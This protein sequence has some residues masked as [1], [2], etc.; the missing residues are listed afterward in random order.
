MGLLC[1]CDYLIF[2]N[3]Q[4]LQD[5]EIQNVIDFIKSSSID[6]SLL[7]TN[8]DARKTTFTLSQIDTLRFPI[9]IGLARTFMSPVVIFNEAEKEA[10]QNF[11]SIAFLKDRELHNRIIFALGDLLKNP[12]HLAISKGIILFSAF[13]LDL[14]FFDYHGISF[15]S[16][17][18]SH[19]FECA[20]ASCKTT[21]GMAKTISAIEL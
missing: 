3:D 14:D 21:S 4:K 16:S 15:D 17:A 10:M 8:A 12:A 6:L 9:L 7:K 2:F 11:M 1:F 20:L 13:I 18:V 5:V 19:I